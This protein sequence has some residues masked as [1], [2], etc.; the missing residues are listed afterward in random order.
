[1]YTSCATHMTEVRIYD[2]LLV[3]ILFYVYLKGSCITHEKMPQLLGGYT[4][5]Q[6]KPTRTP[7]PI[8]FC[9]YSATPPFDI[10]RIKVRALASRLIRIRQAAAGRAHTVFLSE[11]GIVYS[12]GSNEVGQQGRGLVGESFTGG[13]F[14]GASPSTTEPSQVAAGAMS[15][16]TSMKGGGRGGGEGIIGT[17]TSGSGRERRIIA[18]EFLAPTVVGFDE[19]GS[20]A[21]LRVESIAAGDDHCTAVTAPKPVSAEARTGGGGGRRGGGGDDSALRRVFTWG[22]NAAGQCVQSRAAE[23]VPTPQEAALLSGARTVGCG[24]GHTMVVL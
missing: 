9:C 12:C 23:V 16:M 17:S 11:S 19:E 10:C 1:M 7:L 14:P 18:T 24:A 2:F 21:E 6:L 5:A 8:P 3:I 20:L 4:R 15:D 13:T 22:L